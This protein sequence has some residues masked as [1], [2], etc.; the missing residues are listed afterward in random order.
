[1]RGP[2]GA[3]VQQ[4]TGA[5]RQLAG[6]FAEVHEQ[7]AGLLGGPCPGGVRG[8]TQDVHPAGL[9]LYHEEHVQA[10]EEHGVDVEEV[11]CQDSGCLGGEELPVPCQNSRNS[12]ELAF[13]L[14]SSGRSPILVNR[15]VDDLP[16][17]DPAGDVDRLARLM[18]RRSLLARLVRAM[19][20]I[21]PRVLGEDPPEVSF[22]VDQQVVEALAP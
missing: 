8:G 15:P 11:T 6:A 12:S 7:V 1:M 22:T 14:C 10:L 21:M 9:D 13:S 4:C 16:A 17:P 20:V 18:Q 2:E 3:S 19:F 5:T